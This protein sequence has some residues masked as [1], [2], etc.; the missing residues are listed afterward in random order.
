MSTRPE[1]LMV[2]GVQCVLVPVTSDEFDVASSVAFMVGGHILCGACPAR[3]NEHC[4]TTDCNNAMVVNAKYWPI[5]QMR[6]NP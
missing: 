3:G 6:L 1:P 2:N 4:G 5:V